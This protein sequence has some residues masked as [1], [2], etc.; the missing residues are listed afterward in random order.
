MLTLNVIHIIIATNCTNNIFM[1]AKRLKPQK[2]FLKWLPSCI[3]YN[4]IDCII[5]MKQTG[6]GGGHYPFK[7]TRLYIEHMI[8]PGNSYSYM[9]HI[10]NHGKLACGNAIHEKP[11]S[12]HGKCSLTVS[13]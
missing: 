12:M 3:K 4:C 13:S 7:C 6:T 9:L 1:T 8:P 10:A 11:C 5:F 2:P